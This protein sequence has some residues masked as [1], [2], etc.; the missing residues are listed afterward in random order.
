[1]PNWKLSQIANFIVA[2]SSAIRKSILIFFFKETMYFQPWFI[3]P[4]AP[5][6]FLKVTDFKRSCDTCSFVVLSQDCIG[7]SGF[8]CIH[9]NFRFICSS[10]VKNAMSI[11]VGI[12]L[13]LYRI[14]RM[15]IKK[16][17]RI[18]GSFQSASFPFSQNQADVCAFL[19]SKISFSFSPILS[20][21]SF[22]TS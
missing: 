16:L 12:A 18:P 17:A 11:L 22:Q 4:L 1:M 15:A 2:I 5:L 7:Y 14:S 13:N 3:L 21:A 9:T 10:S 6:V 20:P 19:K 8:L